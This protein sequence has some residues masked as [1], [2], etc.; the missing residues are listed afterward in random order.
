MIELTEKKRRWIITQFRIGRSATSIA[1]IQ[2]ISRRYVYKLATKYKKVG[3]CAY[4]G[5]KSG[6]L[7]ISIN[8]S[9]VKKVVEIREKDDYGSEKIHFV[10]TRKGFGV[11][12]HIIQR[13]LNEKKLTEPCLKRRG[14]RK[15]VRYQWP[16]SN[17]MWHCDWSQYNSKEYCVFID[18]RSRKIMAAGKF[19]NATTENT[20]FLLYQAILTNSVC[21]VIELSDKGSQFY[22]NKHD[23]K[24]NKGISKFEK[25]LKKLGV[26]FWTSRRNHPQ[27]N[28]KM[29]KWFDTMKKRFKKHPKESLQDFVRWYNEERI[30]HALAYDTPQKVYWEKL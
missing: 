11:S 23:K 21:P 13:I 3:S 25:E 28:G 22:A 9:F 4:E 17:Y 20:L 14:K 16:I 30:H 8:P 24:G 15:Y 10:M 29:E 19:N 2:K 12:Q 7:K 6:R 27:T 1:R 5:K 26:D 18:D